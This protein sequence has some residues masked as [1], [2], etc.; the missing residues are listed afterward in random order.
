M[1]AKDITDRRAVFV[2]DPFMLKEEGIWYMF[3]EVLSF[4]RSK[5]EI[6][7]ATSKDGFNWSYR[8]IVLSEPFHLSYP[9]VFKYN[10]E[11]YM[12]P[13]SYEKKAVRLYKATRFPNQWEFSANLLLG[14]DFQDS[15]IFNYRNKW[16]LFTCP[17]LQNNE[18]KL[19][20]AEDLRG[21]WLEHARNSVIKDNPYAARCGGRVLVL[22]N[23]VIR[24]AQD[25][26][27]V[28]GRQLCAFEITRLTTNEYEEKECPGNPVLKAS[29]SGW[30]K[31]GMH[32]IDPHFLGQERWFAC[33]DGNDR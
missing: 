2:A 1:T 11:F 6:G 17:T 26:Y 23:K 30:N 4:W 13:E 14:H 19:F 18:L 12:I 24:Y 27:P 5:G 8:Q 33:V 28:Y 3:F 32:N 25:D 15:S 21:P 7:L 31:S 10:G 22:D 16:W 29:G 9:Y 20:Y